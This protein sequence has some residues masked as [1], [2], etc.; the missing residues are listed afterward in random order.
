MMH[1]FF[2]YLLA[3]AG[4]VLYNLLI[5]NVSKDKLDEQDKQFNWKTYK[6]K[7]WDNWAFTLLLSPFLVYYMK[8]IVILF[9]EWLGRDIPQLEIYYIGCGVLTEVIYFLLSK[10]VK[11]RNA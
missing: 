8:D 10:I 6:R 4:W 3:I 2:H 9:S 7:H 5:L 11:L 1:T